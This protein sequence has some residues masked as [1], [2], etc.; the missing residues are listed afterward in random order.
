VPEAWLARCAANWAK[1][2]H[3]GWR[4]RLY[5][6]RCFAD[7]GGGA[8]GDDSTGPAAGEGMG[9]PPPETL[10]ELLLLRA[11]L[12]GLI[13]EAARRACLTAAQ[14]RLI[15]DY[16]LRGARS[17][18]LALASDRTQNAVRQELWSLR[19][20]LREV[21]TGQMGWDAAEV[22]DYLALFDGARRAAGSGRHH[23]HPRRDG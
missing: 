12:L 22:A 5:R 9:A 18:D 10:P 3:R 20:R 14:E 13:R 16:Y 11:E 15:E 4:R 6:E 19:R 21:L 2:S 17:A 8:G 23:G 7:C 1:N